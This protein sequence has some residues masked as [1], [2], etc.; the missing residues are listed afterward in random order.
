MMNASALNFLV[1]QSSFCSFL[2]LFYLIIAFFFYLPVL[3]DCRDGRK[4]CFS[5]KPERR[6]GGM[7][8]IELPGKGKRCSKDTVIIQKMCSNSLSN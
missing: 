2:C 1:I 7:V 4:K 6:V 3:S 8:R 5:R